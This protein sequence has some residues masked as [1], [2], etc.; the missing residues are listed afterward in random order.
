M[1]IPSGQQTDYT[2]ELPQKILG[3]ILA[4]LGPNDLKNAM[5]VCNQWKTVGESSTILWTWVKVRVTSCYSWVKV[6]GTSIWVTVP[7][8]W[9]EIASSKRLSTVV[10]ELCIETSCGLTDEILQKIGKWEKLKHLYLGYL[11]HEVNMSELNPDL[12]AKLMVNVENVTVRGFLT[13][14]NK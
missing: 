9:E 3:L 7:V 6:P 4:K 12:V 1:Q 14:H 5:L 8:P 11:I 2:K 10:E 13:T